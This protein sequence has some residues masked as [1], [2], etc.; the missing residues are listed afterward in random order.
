MNVMMSCP[1]GDVFLG[2]I[3]TNGQQKNMRYIVDELK[4]FIEQVGSQYVTQVC[5]DNAANMLGA[6]TDVI[7]TYCQTSFS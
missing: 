2:S 5:T 3:D 6:M 4:V 1:A 7:N